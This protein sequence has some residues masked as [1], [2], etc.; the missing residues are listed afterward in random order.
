MRTLIG[1][2]NYLIIYA[3][4]LLVLKNV[5]FGTR[6]GYTFT[7]IKTF[8]KQYF[9]AA[10]TLFCTVAMAQV[11]MPAPSPTQTISQEFGMG[12]IEL[13]Y[14]R[15]N[16]KGRKLFGQ[17]SELAPLGELWRTGANAATKVKFTDEVNIAGNK[18]DSGTYVLYT[19]PGEKEWE[20]ILN[21]GLTNWGT[22]GY[23]KEQDVARIKIIPMKMGGAME[24]FTMQVANVQPE[25]CEIHIMW[26]KTAVSIPVTTNVKDRLRAQIETALQTEKKP[27]WQAANFYYEW[28]K[29]YA[30]ALTNIDGAIAGNPKGFWMYL[31]KAKIQKE[32]GQ[33]DAAKAS[34]QKCI[35]VATEAKN[36]DYVRMA[37]EFIASK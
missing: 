6:W 34:A 26:G 14:S 19:I 20:V 12:K 8:M 27:F 3:T 9:V 33:K 25:S 11:K 18:I 24:T 37:Q 13:T 36:A 5:T 15:P 28:D 1:R 4:H 17:K 21:K 10:A 22:D 16:V 32:L 2:Q 23:K 29:D 31:L 7:Q 35:E 30:K